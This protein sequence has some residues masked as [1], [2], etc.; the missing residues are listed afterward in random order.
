M[1]PLP[2]LDG[3]ALVAHLRG[4]ERDAARR[5][6]TLALSAYANRTEI[7]RM[8]EAGFDA[9]LVKPIDARELIGH[10]ARLALRDRTADRTGT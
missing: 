10:V 4:S 3:Y 1:Q 2:A 5:L 6:P 9:S 7:R 8:H